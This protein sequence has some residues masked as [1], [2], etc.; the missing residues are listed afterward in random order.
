MKKKHSP[1]RR[2]ERIEGLSATLPQ[3]R[4]VLGRSFNA[5]EPFLRPTS[6]RASAVPC[7]TPCD[8]A[9]YR[10]VV[11]HSR[12]DLVG[13]CIEGLPPISLTPTDVLIYEIDARKVG[14]ALARALHIE[15]G[16]EPVGEV[17]LVWRLGVYAATPA[18]RIPVLL[19]LCSEPADLHDIAQ[20]L[21][22]LNSDPILLL[23]MTREACSPRTEALLRQRASLH[24]PLEELVEF[25]AGRILALQELRSWLPGVIPAADDLP[26]D[27]IVIGRF[28]CEDGIHWVVN[29]DDKGV[30]YKR[31]KP[32]KGKILEIL[33]DQIGNG[34]IPHRTFQNACSWDDKRYFGD[35]NEAN[36]I[37]KHLT[38]IRNF[39]GVDVIFRKELGVRFAENV[40]KSRE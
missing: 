11:E 16:I 35:S 40:V 39:L 38:D 5:F 27:A 13:V 15:P 2:L 29:G 6:R 3:W 33:F 8:D 4:Q 28:V 14:D 10:R 18:N 9:C 21:L 17:P 12:N 7:S 37:Q 36:V 32:I 30:F 20:S 23:T 1:W 22:L 24:A 31:G 34:W 19:S 25:Q 26:S